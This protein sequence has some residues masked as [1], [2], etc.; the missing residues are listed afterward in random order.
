M[1]NLFHVFQKQVQ[2]STGVEHC[3][4]ANLTSA[5]DINLIVSKTN[6]LQIYTIRYEKI[7]KPE[8]HSNGDGGGSEDKQ[9]IETRP[10]L[11]LVLEKSLFG[12]IESLNVIRFPD[13]QRDAIILTFRD[14][15]I[16]VL[17]YNVDLMDLEIRSMHYYERDEYKFGRQH[18][19]HP[20]LCKVD[21]Q[22]RCAVILLYDHSMVV[23]PFKQAISILDD[24]EDTTMNI[25]DDDISSIMQYAQQQQQTQ[26]PYYQQK[27]YSSSLLDPTDFCFLHGYYEPTLLIL[28]EPTQ[29]WT[30]RISAKKLTSVL[31]AVSL[32]LSAK[33]TPTIWSI[34]KM[35]YNC[36]SLLPVPEPLGGSLVV[37]PNILF[38]VN[39]SS[40]YGL[41]VNEYAQT[42]TGDQFP[43]PLDNTLNLVFTLERST[44]VFLESDRFIC[45]LKGGELLIFHLISD[46]RS[47]QRIHVSKAG[48]SVLSSCICVLSSN[49]I[50]L[51]S[52]L[53][54]SLLLLYT[55]TTVSD[56][57]EEHENFSNPYKKQKT[58]ELF[59]LFD[60]DNDTVQMQKQQQLQKQQE[61]EEDDEDDIFK[62][63][64]S[65][66]KTYQLGICDH[67]TNLGPITDMVIGN[68][69]DMYQQQKEQEED[70]DDYN[71]PSKSSDSATTPHNLDLVTCSG[72][73]KNGSIVQ[74]QKNVR[75]DL[76]SS[77]PILDVTNS[78]TLYYESEILQKTQHNITGKKRTIDS[79]STESESPNTE[80]SSNSDSKQS[81][82]S[83]NDDSNSYHQFLYLSLSDSTLIYEISQD[84][85]EIGK[86]NQSTLAMGN[87]FGKSRIIQVT[88]NSVKLISGAS[89]V[90]QELS[91]PTLKI[92]QCYIV[93]PFILIHFQNGSISIYQGNEQVHQ[94]M[95]FPFL[96]D[97]LNI[98]ASSL[99]I[100]HHNLYFKST[101]SSSILD[102][103]N[104][105][106][107]STKVNL[108]LIDSQGIIE[109][110][111]LESKEL[112]YQYNNFFNEADILHWNENINDYENTISQYLNL[113]KTNKLTNGQHQP[114]I[115]NNNNGELKHSKITE[116]SVHFF[117]QMEWSNPYIIGINQLGDIIIYRG[118]KTPKDNI[119]FR[120]FNHGIIT[121]PLEN[122]GGNGNDGKRIIEFSNIGGKRGLFITGKSPLWL[123]CEK[124]YLRVHCMNNEGAINIFTP[125]HNEN[126]SNGFIYFTESSALR[127][128]QLPMD[129]NFEN[130]FPI[131]KYM[132]K[133]TCHKIS[134]DQVSK[135][136]CLILSYPVETGEIPESDQRKPVI[137]EYKYQV[138]L[139]DRRDLSTFID[140]FSL[141]EKETALS[142]KMVQLKFTDPD[143]QTR[144]KPFLA[145][146]TAFT[147]G[148]DTQCKGRILIFEII[149]HIGQQRLNLLYEKEQKGPVTAL[150]STN[151]Y[152][153]MTIGPKLIVNNFMS[154]SLIGLA[155]YDAQLY[156]VSI[157]TI[158]NLI[159][160]GDMFKSIY[161]LKWKDGKQLVLLSKDYQS[162]NVFTSDYIINQKTLSLL[163][164]DLDKNILMFNF[165]PKDPNSR[166]GKMMLCKA[167][168]HIASNI[169]KF[170][171]LPLRSTSNSTTSTTSNGNGNG[172]NKNHNSMI[173]PDQQMVFGGTLDGGLVTLIPMNEQQ[174]NLLS[175]LQTK[176]Y[177]IPHGCGLN[178]KSY[179]SFKS[180][181][182]H[183]S[184]SIQQPQKF[185]LD[186]DL[187]H[188]YLTLNNNDKHLLAIQINS[189]PDEIISILNQ[190]NYSS[191]T[192]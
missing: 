99:F 24:D 83:S 165:D 86:F 117:N 69:Y 28:H 63:K 10:C 25:N 122:S 22:Q 16:S 75:P 48:G 148:E 2:Q 71:P 34:D 185:I 87:I 55:E 76:I 38:Y 174:F 93:D 95:E 182:Q 8:N 20:P 131:R 175:H 137:V 150:S 184:P 127:I 170:I 180:Y 169:Q 42:D 40:R 144:L 151:G 6:I 43:F 158:K 27:S 39:Q 64:K 94:L 178:P 91:F 124:N 128:C 153:L 110:Y 101:S 164:A 46:G 61:E 168:F 92:R 125:F 23:L 186:G 191:S 134:Y 135:C 88:V 123:F 79:I 72:Y 176:L 167:D 47:V 26:N 36:E 68:S 145:V 118:F 147:Y 84:L 132:V 154:G 179:R 3:V 129:M 29:T 12:N 78:W 58:S 121:R 70:Q 190:I 130:Q 163:V 157:S 7:E 89:T 41:A 166:Q 59:D 161:F 74:L 108:I 57:G 85:K 149:T 103:T 21:H 142:M 140:S 173:I 109:I 60:E 119:L 82:D 152:L 189:T 62:E 104:S 107:L 1:S 97:R 102:T 98:T 188:H 30:S 54:D 15:K 172:N 53:G 177:H 33:Q 160:I 105:S 44:Y 156:I 113:N 136:Y 126:C 114:N 155:F 11:D 171:R 90:T 106:Q 13:E 162:L 187:I 51:G 181:Q 77:I 66:I 112:L 5:N 14:A 67:I 100:D 31:S 120:K 56:S 96:K 19:K 37:A 65:Q 4:K 111:K 35:P 192:F 18:F 50:F 146:G 116:L 143:G 80:E 52:R 141:Q 139:I 183:Y 81:K 49:L 73:G 159:I 32:N 9:K 45:S 133:N 115:N 17:E 138:K